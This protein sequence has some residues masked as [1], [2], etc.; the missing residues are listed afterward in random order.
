MKKIT[1]EQLDKNWEQL[2]AELSQTLGRKPDLQ[3][4]LFL[5]GVQELGQLHRKFSKEEKQYLMHIAVCQLLCP[6]GYFVFKHRDEDGWPHYE[7]IKPMPHDANNLPAQ[8]ELLKYAVL[9][10]LER[11]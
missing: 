1:P 4:I 5:I 3:G 9:R 10:Y 8:E 7:A 11:I 2:T 6:D